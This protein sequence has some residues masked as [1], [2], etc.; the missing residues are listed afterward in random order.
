MLP[1]DFFRRAVARFPERVALE[2]PSGRVTFADLAGRV[3]ALAAALQDRVAAESGRVGICATNS[4]EHVVALLACLAAGRTWVPLNPRS[5]RAELEAVLGLARPDVVLCEDVCRDRLP[6]WPAPIL[7]L[8]PQRDGPAGPSSA[9]WIIS[10]AGRRPAPVFPDLSAVQALKFTSGSSGKAKGVLQSY[11]CWNT[12]VA[13]ISHAFAFAPDERFLA[14]API[15]HGTSCFLLPV[16]AAGGC[17]VLPPRAK[18]DAILQAFAEQG[19]TGSYMTPTMIYNLLAEPG[20]RD[21]SYPAVRHLIYSGAPMR[22]EQ[23][24]QTLEVFPGALE[25]SYGQAEAPQIISYMRGADFADP[26]N[27]G[28]VGH[29]GLLVRVGILDD[30]ANELPAGEIGEICVRGDL[31]ANGYLDNPE[32]EA[33]SFVDGWLKTGDLGRFDERGLLYIEGRKKDVII[34]G[35]FNIHPKD[36]EEVLGRHDA[37]LECSVFGVED[38]KWGEAVHAAVELRAGSRVT[39]SE[40]IA[41]VKTELDSVKAPKRIHV[42]DRLPRNAVGKVVR[43]EAKAMAVQNTSEQLT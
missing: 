15:T 5:G 37:V 36:V 24:R 23:I 32:A 38:P 8:S 9:D 17:I 14:A 22:M 31:V 43:R 35:G 34:S 42:V 29:P 18:P 33:E 12:H 20:A 28:S 19:V 21:R 1:I 16:L 41:F 39:E 26:R 4:P 3:D 2:S 7:R 30:A 13:S 10:H 11:R 40:L 25:T 6:D 27:H